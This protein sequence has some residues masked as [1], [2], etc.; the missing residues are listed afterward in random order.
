MFYNVL[1]QD[2]TR[3][4]G[5]GG[6][7]ASTPLWAALFSQINAIFRDQGLPNLGYANDLLYIAAAIDPASFNDVTLGNNISSFSLGGSS[8]QTITDQNKQPD[9]TISDKRI[10]PTGYGYYAG[11]GY[12]MTTGLGSPDA[13]PLAR[14]LSEIAHAQTY[15]S[16][17]PNI[18]NSDGQGG[19]T[20]GAN[21]SLLLQTSSATSTIGTVSDGLKSV[22]F[23]SQASATFAWTSRFA[24][25]ALQPDFD[26]RL[27]LLFDKNAQGNV[28]ETQ[29]SS[30]QRL[31]VALDDTAALA[32]QSLLT[33][34]FGFADF[35]NGIGVERFARP[36][37]IAE[38]AGG[39]D[40]A[41]VVARL[42]QDGKDDTALTFYRVDDLSGD[43]GKL[44][45]GD[46]GYA[47]AAQARAYQLS[48]G[49]TSIGGLGY[50]NF[51][52]TELL[53]V[54]AGDLIAMTLTNNTHGNTFWAF[55]QANEVVNGAPVG[56]L[57]NYGANTW[58]WEDTFGGGDRDYNDMV[59]G[60]DFTSASG[61]NL[62]V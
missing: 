7:S 58:G 35:M 31:S 53:H 57:W 56:H 30:G 44:K 5:G 55:S 60:L 27:V 4:G 46:P 28:A 10:T 14:T 36:V 12:D 61:R 33:T 18:V 16:N 52:Q 9:G 32:V 38:T 47:A 42:R 43:I 29:V 17:E 40:N 3:L 13:L 34:A 45:P 22:T 19:W 37:A 51:A 49:G 59:V 20:S 6:T 39:Q 23:S 24:E 48:T 8:P 1:N 25:D 62:L 15:F 41:T 2:M 50:G 11:P 26:P 21:Q 54:D